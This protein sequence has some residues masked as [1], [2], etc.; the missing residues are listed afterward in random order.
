M[1]LGELEGDMV[2]K[3]RETDYVWV[4]HDGGGGSVVCMLGGHR[5][6]W[7]DWPESLMQIKACALAFSPEVPGG[8]VQISIPTTL[9]ARD[10]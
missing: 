9:A 1:G 8:S 5:E 7:T 4:Q 10:I 2:E 6:G 3:M